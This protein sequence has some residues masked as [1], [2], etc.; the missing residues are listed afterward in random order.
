MKVKSI[1][2]T[3]K[4]LS[5]KALAVGYQP[6]TDFQIKFGTISTVYGI[7]C[8]ENVFHYLILDNIIPSLPDWYPAELFESVD[9]SLPINWYHKYFGEDD[10][11]G[12]QALWGYREMI[13]DYAHYNDLIERK[14]EAIRIFLRRKSEM[15]ENEG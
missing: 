9:Q 4:I 15:D 12:I 11:R 5:T 6:T 3:G 8:W 13:T 1:W 14:D 7:S 2:L 10:Q